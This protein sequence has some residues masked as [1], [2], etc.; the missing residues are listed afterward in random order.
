MLDTVSAKEIPKLYARLG[1][2]AAARD[3]LIE[4]VTFD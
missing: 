3:G 2:G 4:K 1:D